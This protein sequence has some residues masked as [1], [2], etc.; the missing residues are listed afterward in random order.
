MSERTKNEF[1]NIINKFIGDYCDEVI[2]ATINARKQL[3]E[4]AGARKILQELRVAETGI[5]SYG[6]K[7]IE[8]KTNDD[9]KN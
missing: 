6:F 2:N 7:I 9:G 8:E 5:D 3:A 1:L 4:E